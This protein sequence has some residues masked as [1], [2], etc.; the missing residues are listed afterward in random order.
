MGHTHTRGGVSILLGLS[1]PCPVTAIVAS[2]NYPT[3]EA[4]TASQCPLGWAVRSQI[5][6]GQWRRSSPL[7][8]L[9]LDRSSWP[10]STAGLRRCLRVTD[11]LGSFPMAWCGIPMCSAQLREVGKAGLM[12]EL[13]SALCLDLGLRLRDTGWHKFLG[14]PSEYC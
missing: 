7:A 1:T 5:K 14:C 6:T 8:R 10:A 3:L 2:P 4:V 9:F 12:R 13:H 11:A